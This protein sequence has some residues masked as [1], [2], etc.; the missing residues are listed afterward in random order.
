MKYVL[1]RPEG[2]F[3]DMLVQIQKCLNYCRKYKR[4]LLIDTSRSSYNFNF[5]EYFNINTNINNITDTEQVNQ[6]ISDCRLRVIPGH[7]RGKL[8]TYQS[9][10]SEKCKN[11]VDTNKRNQ[12]TFNFRESYFEDILLH[13][14]CGGGD[15]NN[16][17]K[18]LT[19][20]LPIVKDFKQKYA[21]L[22]KPYIA[23]QVR[24]TDYKCDYQQLYLDNKA[25][26]DDKI[27]Y[28]ATDDKQCIEHFR[29]LGIKVYNFTTFPDKNDYASLHN[30]KIDN[31][32]KLKDMISD[33][34][35][36]AMSDKLISNSQGGYI[37]LAKFAHANKQIMQIKILGF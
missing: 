37:R 5:V 7:V 34:L 23:I 1:C 15:A 33:L 26:I 6:I 12:L 27:I 13:D 9:M 14:Q 10:Y 22:P 30:S 11:F 32:T 31:V 35:L 19:L 4:V 18:I 17:F 29:K 8:L 2:G 36:L 16:M 20:K 24:N 28:L 21:Q 25:D 3:N